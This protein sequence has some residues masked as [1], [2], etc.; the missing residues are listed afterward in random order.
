MI[1]PGQVAR[2]GNMTRQIGDQ[3]GDLTLVRPDG[4]PV[5]LS[6][7]AGRAVLLVFLRHLA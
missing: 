1:F 3:V 2:G 4:S 6:A 5:P 7:F